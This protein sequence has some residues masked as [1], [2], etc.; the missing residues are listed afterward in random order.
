MTVGKHSGLLHLLFYFGFA[1]LACHELDA[2]ARHEWRLLPLLNKLNDDS[3][4]IVFV[5]LH[6]PAFTLIIWLTGHHTDKIRW[7]GQIAFD[8][9]LIVHGIA[10]YL[11]SGHP[12]NEFEPPIETI[13]VYGGALIGL[14]HLAFMSFSRRHKNPA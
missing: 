2:V 14:T 4:L 13:T 11:F 7:W 12:L 1:L 3:G 8:L 5:L 6:V 9:F 10:H